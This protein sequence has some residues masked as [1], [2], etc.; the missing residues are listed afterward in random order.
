MN[1]EKI[2][3][4]LVIVS[5]SLTSINILIVQEISLTKEEAIEISRNSKLVRSF[6]EDADR[7][8]LEVH[9]LNKTQAGMDHGVWDI[10]WYIHPNNAP[11]AFAYVV[12]HTIDE[13]TGEILRE[14][15]MS[16][17]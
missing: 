6:L 15:A 9:H 16:L 1:L 3:A 4:I 11:S 12:S 2:M 8:T 17:R 10:T 7:Y 5:F 13:E 14:E